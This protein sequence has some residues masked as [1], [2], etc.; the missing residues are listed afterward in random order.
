M[1]I[2]KGDKVQVLT[3]KERGKT[4]VVEKVIPKSNM[5]IVSGLNIAKKM[6]KP[7]KKAPKGGKIEFPAPIHIS[8]LGYFCPT[9]EKATKVSYK[10]QDNKKVRICSSCQKSDTKKTISSKK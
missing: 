6:A 10:L 2:K 3:G 5:A 9:C 7:S 8:N 1:K 4:G